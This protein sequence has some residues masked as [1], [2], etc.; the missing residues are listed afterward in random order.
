LEEAYLTT[1]SL[2]FRLQARIGKFRNTVGKTNRI[3]PHAL[4]YIDT[5]L[6]YEHFFGGEGLNDQGISL[7]WLLPNP[8]FFQEATFEVTRGPAESESFALDEGGRLLYTGHLTNFWDLSRDAT[9]EV[10]LTGIYGANDLGHSTG[11]GGVDVTYKWKPLQFNTSRSLTLQTEVFLSR[12]RT[13]LET[14]DGLG[15]YGLIGWQ[16]A[17][18]WVVTGRFDHADLPD[19]PHWNQEAGS[20]TLAWLLSEFQKIE[21]GG[22]STWGPK[23]DRSYQGL[24]RLV[25]VI[26]THGAHAY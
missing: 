3:H 12:R 18:R 22:R 19:D 7:N 8:R 15:F 11:I 10:G 1:L 13:G 14:I 26:G 20:I 6:V 24:V 9:L 17:R 4:S 2:P 5:P 25:F 23:T 16:L 21:L